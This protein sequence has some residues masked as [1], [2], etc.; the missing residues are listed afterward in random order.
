MTLFEFI[1]GSDQWLRADA[2]LHHSIVSS[3]ARLARNL[4]LIP[5][6]P[7]AGNAQLREVLDRVAG[8]IEGNPFFRD[9]Q[10]VTISEI[11]SLHRLY[12]KESH[13]VSTEFEQGGE[14]RAIFIS[15]DYRVSIMINE[16]DHVRI[17]CL[18][19][20]FQL[21]RAL[22]LCE[23]VEAQLDA[24]LGFARSERLGVLTACPTNAGTGLRLSVM[25]H[26]PGLVII[27]KIDEITR[28]INQ[29]GLTVRGIYGEHSD[30]IGDF[31]QVSN[32][33]TLGKEHL[34][35]CAT[36]ESVAGQVVERELKARDALF[37]QKPLVVQDLI[38][39]ALA[40]LQHAW[41][42]DSNEALTHLSKIRLG[43]DRGF[44]RPLNHPE[45][46]RLMIEVQ[47]AHLQCMEGGKL[48][49][50]QRDNLRAR[51][52][53]ERLRGVSYN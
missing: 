2:P 46:S 40:V 51:L 52:L 26:L 7:R 27:D 14:F 22:S 17:Q 33:V 29:Y 10:R 28:N 3:R 11:H 8:A 31:F 35:L 15:P 21:R 5:F 16:E 12:L 24:A 36:L 49:P 9:F 38:S 48:P 44:L 13:L 34:E 1:K 53:H 43:I 32:E 41:I 19:P 45:L 47:P 50:E 25:M 6:A 23:E 4:P 42:L 18:A 20:G 39:R 30:H 37:E